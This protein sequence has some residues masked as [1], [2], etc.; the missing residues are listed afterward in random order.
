MGATA[1]V[2]PMATIAARR[3]WRRRG[4]VVRS[5]HP[6]N[7]CAPMAARN[8][9]LKKNCRTCE[10]STGAPKLAPDAVDDP[11]HL[12]VVAQNLDPFEP[13]RREFVTDEWRL[14][15]T[16]FDGKHASLAK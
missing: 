9:A 15:R 16:H 7:T 12:P 2:S 8:V 5:H 3:R 4:N 11:L 14:A 1:N 6:R 10:V 13:P